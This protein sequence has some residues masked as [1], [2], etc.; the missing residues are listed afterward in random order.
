M[1]QLNAAVHAE[2][3]GN[4]RMS[5]RNCAFS[6]Y[7]RQYMCIHA[8]HVEICSSVKDAAVKGISVGLIMPYSF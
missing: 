7:M 3:S 1:R 8:V 4:A 5:L 2:T 6:I